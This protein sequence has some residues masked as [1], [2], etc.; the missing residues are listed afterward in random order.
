LIQLVYEIAEPGIEQEVALTDLISL[1]FGNSTTDE[2]DDELGLGE[3]SI[4]H[5]TQSEPVFMHLRNVESGSDIIAV[6][7][8]ASKLDMLQDLSL[9]MSIALLQTFSLIIPITSI[10]P[11]SFV[12]KMVWIASYFEGI[13]D[14]KI[15]DSYDTP[16]YNYAYNVLSNDDNY[17]LDSLYIIG[18]SLGGGISQAVG[19]QLYY[20][21]QRYLKKNV[22]IKSL[23]LA[24]PGM[25]FG[26]KKFNFDLE[27]LYMTSIVI[28][29]Q[30]DIVSTIDIHGGL[31]QNLQCNTASFAECHLLGNILC[32][33]YTHCHHENCK[34]PKM[35]DRFCEMEQHQKWSQAYNLITANQSDT[36]TQ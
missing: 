16:V 31:L 20:M 24:A 17:N 8:T 35:Y 28:K 15:R 2:T 21:N 3:W 10:A 14:D 36:N 27:A 29:P 1:Y 26:S 22:D 4:I 25:L 34:N 33:L 6:R 23:S 19:A 30:H 32:E 9:Y 7:G 18:H 12:I 13:V 11:T 5:Y